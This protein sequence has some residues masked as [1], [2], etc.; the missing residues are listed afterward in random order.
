[1][2]LLDLVQG[3]KGNPMAGRNEVAKRLGALLDCLAGWGDGLDDLE[4]VADVIDLDPIARALCTLDATARAALR[5]LEE[6]V[7]R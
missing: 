7:V 4:T 2:A 5:R 6:A 3:D 1:V